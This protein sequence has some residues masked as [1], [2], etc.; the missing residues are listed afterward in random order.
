MHQHVSSDLHEEVSKCGAG[1]M[2][3]GHQM[4]GHV[5]SHASYMHV[6]GVSVKDALEVKRLQARDD[7]GGY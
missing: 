6:R 5:K 2:E 3:D 4:K 1:L 7:S